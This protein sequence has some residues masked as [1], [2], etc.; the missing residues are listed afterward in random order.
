MREKQKI[1][2][3]YHNIA[4]EEGTLWNRKAT[5]IGQWKAFMEGYILP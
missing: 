1:Y 5:G 4:R 2:A 3:F